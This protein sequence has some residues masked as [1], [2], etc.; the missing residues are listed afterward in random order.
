MP[1]AS[2]A[3]L[4]N[5]SKDLEKDTEIDE[6]DSPTSVHPEEIESS[7]IHEQRKSPVPPP[8]GLTAPLP[9]QD[10]LPD[11]GYGWVCVAVCFIINA[12]TWG[13][14]SSYGIFLNY[15]LS[16][17][18]FPGANSTH[19]AFIGG[20]SMAAALLFS[21]LATI[22]IRELGTRNTLFIGVFFQTVSFVGASFST[23]I[24][25]LFLSQGACFGIGLGFLFVGSVG[26]IPQW[27]LRHRSLAN[28]I[29]ASGSG[30]GGL[31]YSLASN[32]MIQNVGLAWAFRILAIISFVVNFI[33]AVLLRDRNK[34]VGSTFL[35]FDVRL[36][37]KW[38]FWALLGYGFFSMLGYVILIFSIPNY[39]HKVGLTAK[40]GSVI[41][42]VLN[43]GQGI[44][45]PPIG[46]FSDAIGRINMAGIMSFF[47]AVLALVVWT[48]AKSYGVRSFH[49]LVKQRIYCR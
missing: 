22:S 45:R 8:D 23:Q 33:A 32:A 40:Q 31:A 17:N 19:Y 36:F 7:P 38:E 15:Y 21:P 9:P 4:T 39:A 1:S 49:L 5:L 42:A 44:G 43:L 2:K 46:Y 48:N 41:G 10:A 37:K 14:N 47:S 20:L 25:Q 24:W 29:S 27:F 12:H 26:V 3:S 16:H 34:Q 30:F 11:G 35:A 6:I 13:M 28:G 18:L